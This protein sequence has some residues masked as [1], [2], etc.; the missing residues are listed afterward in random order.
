MRR[1]AASPFSGS[2]GFG[3]NSSC[4][5]K[6]SNTLI[7]SA[8]CV[9]WSVKK[10]KS[11]LSLFSAC[12]RAPNIGLH[13]WLITSKHTEPPLRGRRAQTRRRRKRRRQEAGTHTPSVHLSTLHRMTCATHAPFVHVRVVDFVDE[14]D[15]RA[16]VRIRFRQLHVHPPHTAHIGALTWPGELDVELRHAVV[17]HLHLPVAHEP[18]CG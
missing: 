4:G 14:A 18:A 17:C 13:V 2:V 16:L 11:L 7:R 1:A 5:R 15:G 3:Y 6:T 10:V 9:W 12:Q 8:S